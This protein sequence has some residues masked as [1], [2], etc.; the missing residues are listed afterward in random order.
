MMDSNF[1]FYDYI[2]RLSY[3]LWSSAGRPD[4]L[5]EKFWEM[6]CDIAGECEDFVYD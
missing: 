5:S 3:Q 1:N 6:A 2:C 4:G